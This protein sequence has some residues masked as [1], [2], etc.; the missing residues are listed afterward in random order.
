MIFLF[1]LTFPKVSVCNPSRD[2]LMTGLRPDTTK[3]YSFDKTFK[4]HMSFPLELSRNGYE[5]IDVGKIFHGHDFEEIQKSN[6]SY[7]IKKSDWYN[8][9]NAEGEKLNATVNPDNV[10][11]EN[12][13]RDAI[14]TTV[15]IKALKKLMHS[16]TN[17]L[18]AIG[19]KLPHTILHFPHR[20]YDLYRN[21]SHIWRDVNISALTFPKSVST[22]AY[23]CCA[24]DTYSYLNHEGAD[25]ATREHHFYG[26]IIIQSCTCLSCN[27]FY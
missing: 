14:S 7:G 13:F 8:Y 21:T 1:F 10:T 11:P 2:S 3:S 22:I 6:I 25:K 20:Y 23:R 12:R 4:P 15:A 9:Q 18:L 24:F 26:K 5:I 19:Y 17:F 27:T 16:D